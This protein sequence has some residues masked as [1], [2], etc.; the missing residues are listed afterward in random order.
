MTNTIL[1]YK[2]AEAMGMAEAQKYSM[3]FLNKK[4]ESVAKQAK[5][6]T[7][8]AKRLI[9]KIQVK[10]S[11]NRKNQSVNYTIRVYFITEWQNFNFSIINE[12]HLANRIENAVSKIKGDA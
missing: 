2:E 6:L 8:D 12:N 11:W 9:K 3:N 10:T 4:R 5:N 7:N 1:T